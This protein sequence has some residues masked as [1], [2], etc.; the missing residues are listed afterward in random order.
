M[1]HK[2]I[3]IIALLVT[4]LCAGGFV[5]YKKFI[6]NSSNDSGT[7]ALLEMLLSSKEEML[8]NPNDPKVLLKEASSYYDFIRGVFSANE[9]MMLT[10]D[11]LPLGSIATMTSAFKRLGY[12]LS[13]VEKSKSKGD[14]YYLET[15][16]KKLDEIKD[17][18]LDEAIQYYRKSFQLLEPDKVPSAEYYHELGVLYY[19]KGRAYS[20]EATKYIL[21]SIN[22]D[23]KNPWGL[24]FLG[25]IY[26][27]IDSLENAIYYYKKAYEILPNNPIILFNLAWSEKEA[28]F[29]DE[30]ERGF[31]EL[32]NTMSL[33]E[34]LTPADI[35]VILKAHYSLGY[36]ALDRKKYP[37]AV[38]EFALVTQLEPMSPE[39]YYWLGKSFYMNNQK[40]DA[41]KAWGSLIKIDPAF[42]DVQSLY[43][44]L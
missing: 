43:E 39:G 21:K 29:L 44:N 33:E 6:S 12:D 13:D 15:F 1:T 27:E 20:T 24:C 17:K 34:T 4:S 3:S 42:K 11:T 35:S 41:K 9:S 26:Y 32:V 16:Q 22:M 2:K 37:D 7:D 28:G 25:N 5:Y 14:D 30:S 23:Y 31:H 10:D 40:D 38:K 8:L 36:I 18:M 19:M